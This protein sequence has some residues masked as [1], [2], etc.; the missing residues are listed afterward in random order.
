MP[1]FRSVPDSDVPAFRSLVSYAFRPQEGPTDPDDVDPEDIPEEWKIGR[2]RALYDGDDLL[3]VCKLI[4]FRTRVRGDYHPMDGLS[5]VASPPESRRQGLVG[6]MLAATLEESRE[7]GTY[8][9]ALW[10]FKRTFY[11]QYGWA[12]CSRGVEHDIDP[13]LLS[14]TRDHRHGTFVEVDADEWER[15]DV[16]HDA[17][18]AR[19]ELT[20]DRTE[21]WWRH[22]VFTGYDDDPFVYGWERDGELAAYVVYSVESGD[23]GRSLNVRDVAYVDHDALLALLRFFADHDSQVDSVQFW[24]PADADLMD[25]VPNADDLDAT[26]HVGPMVRL[27]DVPDAL[28]AL[29]FP[30]DVAGS[31]VLAVDDPLAAWN[32]DTFRLVV[33]DGAASVKPTDEDVD[34]ELGVGALSQLYVGYRGADELATVGDLAGEA[35]AVELLGEAFPTRKTLLRE[36]F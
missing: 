13:D 34:V 33:E 3:T 27:V 17:H 7:R 14:F 18:G 15:L 8:L 12:T 36:G 19:Y 5:A 29:S 35:S 1:D 31:L 2:R 24:T 6:E 21:E 16:V 9:S 23:D 10:P 11:G 30:D 20:M 26:L 28:E 4:D 22:R 25:V 32:D